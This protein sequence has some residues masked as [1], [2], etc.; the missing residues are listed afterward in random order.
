MERRLKEAFKTALAMVLA[1]GIA[2]SLD[3][4]NPYWAG[5]AVAVIS[6]P[7]AGQSIEKGALRLLGTVVGSIAALFLLG[8]FP[9]DRWLFMAGV[10]VYLGFCAYMIQRGRHQYF[11][12][13][14]GLVALIISVSG[15]PHSQD[16]FY[17][18]MTRTLETGL[19]IIVYTVVSVFLWPQSSARLLEGTARSLIDTQR[20]RY[21]AYRALEKGLG[22]A[23]SGQP[24]PAQEAQLIARLGQ[25][26]NAASSESYD[27][28]ER[29]DDW[30][31]LHRR[32]TAL[33]RTLDSWRESLPEIG[34]MDLSYLIPNSS[35]IHDE[36]ENT[37]SEIES[38]WK[39]VG[40]GFEPD[41]VR[42]EINEAAVSRLSHLE[43]AALVVTQSNVGKIGAHSR[44][45]LESVR[46]LKGLSEP[47]GAERSAK[48]SVRG[49]WLDPERFVAVA[50]VVATLWLSFLIWVYFDPPGHDGFVMLSSIFALALVMLPQARPSM[51]FMPFFLGALFAGAIYFFVMPVLS[52]YAQLAV[53]L[54]AATFVIYFVFSEPRQGLARLGGIVSLLIL[55]SIQNQQ[56]YS[57][58]HF[59]NTTVMI[60]LGI[61]FVTALSYVPNSPRPEK[62]LL[63]LLS[64]F[65]RSGAYLLHHS[66]RDRS[67]RWSG[68]ASK[69]NHCRANLQNIPARLGGVTQ[70]IDFKAVSP[71]TR[72][73]IDNLLVQIHGLKVSIQELED[74]HREGLK[75]QI[76][77]GLRED[78]AAWR[79]A[80]AQILQD[81]SNNVR[82]DTHEE[83]SKKLRSGLEK[84]EARVEEMFKSQSG[85]Q[86][87]DETLL[88]VYR[89]L[90]SYRGLSEALA[91]Y[92]R[93][94]DG[95]NW[96]RLHEARF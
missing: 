43:R 22:Q 77:L 40:S 51:L 58:P 52:S 91:A 19:G 39:G 54:F 50:K 66:G 61:I 37:F 2:L 1:F 96:S 83:L 73:Q 56:S 28:R 46:R 30:I 33:S 35:V 53:V 45:I 57:F 67:K 85:A 11:W 20:R 31:R 72:D 27:V 89:L 17:V 65:A 21:Q 88:N 70:V 87:N 95:I 71:V 74:T 10:S 7:T 90:G 24:N 55:T 18:A 9:Q 68:R 81:W 38:T 32:L 64:R 93:A 82:P 44:S 12:F 14:S 62:M 23:A 80:L 78:L 13:V 41:R 59:A 76:P 8:L 92:S 25:L 47:V 15:G 69:L 86:A 5:L 75:D 49:S 48:V 16:A 29:K 94:S 63:R 42:T 60:L 34:N 3:W 84:I 4:A 26:L 6:L 36:I 79:L